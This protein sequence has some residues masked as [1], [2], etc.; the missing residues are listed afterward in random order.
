[1]GAGRQGAGLILIGIL[2]ELRWNRKM[3][4][5]GVDPRI[6]DS[7]FATS[8]K[9]EIWV[10]VWGRRRRSTSYSPQV[11]LVLMFTMIPRHDLLIGRRGKAESAAYL[12]HFWCHF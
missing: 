2:E 6:G 7:M 1:M 8:R 10:P 5:W 3:E 12:C 9:E 4:R 11:T